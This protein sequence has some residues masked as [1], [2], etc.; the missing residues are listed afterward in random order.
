MSGPNT[1]FER[2]TPSTDFQTPPACSFKA[3]ARVRIQ[4]GML[5]EVPPD[6]GFV[7]ASVSYAGRTLHHGCPLAG[8]LCATGQLTRSL[9]VVGFQHIKI[10]YI[11]MP[12]QAP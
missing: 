7:D 1:H 9:D 11:V 6:Q 2:E 12:S 3:A 8:R 4:L 5:R 10:C